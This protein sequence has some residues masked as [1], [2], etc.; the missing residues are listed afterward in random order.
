[1]PV[2]ANVTAEPLTDPDAIRE[3]LRVQ[4]FSPVRWIDTLQRM[5]DLGCSLFIEIGP[6]DVLAGL[7]KRTLPEAQVVSFGSI[8]QLDSVRA[9]LAEVNA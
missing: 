3:E 5:S 4:V 8:D 9:L 2:V 7:V 1:V 6:G